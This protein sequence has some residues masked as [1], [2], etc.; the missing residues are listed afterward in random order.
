MI[1]MLCFRHY[2][3]VGLVRTNAEGI[4]SINVALNTGEDDN[5]DIPHPEVE[6]VDDAV[7]ESSE[8]LKVGDFVECNFQNFQWYH[9]RVADISADGSMCEVLYHDG[10]VSSY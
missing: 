8:P 1:P 4:Q 5:F 2:G 9:G 10:D 3:T 7:K 6:A